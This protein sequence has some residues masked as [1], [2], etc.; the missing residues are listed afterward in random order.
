MRDAAGIITESGQEPTIVETERIGERR[1][2]MVGIRRLLI[3]TILLLSEFFG[4]MS[5]VSLDLAR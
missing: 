2:S 5:L 3:A 1:P 4:P